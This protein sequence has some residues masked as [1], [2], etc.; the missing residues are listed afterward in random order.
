MLI[1]GV[2]VR[3]FRADLFEARGIAAYRADDFTTAVDLLERSKRNRIW[4]RNGDFYLGLAHSAL[5]EPAAAM[6]AFEA[7]LRSA[8]SFRTYLHLAEIEIEA[9]RLSSGLRYLDFLKDLHPEFNTRRDGLYLRGRV[10]LLR[11]DPEAARVHWERILEDDPRYHRAMIGLGYLDLLGGDAQRARIRYMEAR[12]LIRAKIQDP[13]GGRDA[14][15]PRRY[16]RDLSV[17][18]R[19]LADLDARDRRPR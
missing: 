8:P 15:S 9:G 3:E 11:K 17:V 6:S 12:R 18:D 1:G 4:P 16:V 7:S 13:P 14:V 2:A 10:A 19:A 5:D